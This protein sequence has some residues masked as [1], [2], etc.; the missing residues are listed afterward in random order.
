MS[1]YVV[2]EFL[3][4]TADKKIVKEMNINKL[5]KNKYKSE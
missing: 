1:S 5:Q 2:K 4:L 3:K